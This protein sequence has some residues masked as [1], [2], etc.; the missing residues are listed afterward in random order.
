M[1]NKIIILL[2]FS[3]IALLFVV[4]I[5]SERYTKREAKGIAP[6]SSKPT[7]QV[8]ISKTEAISLAK[9]AGVKAGYKV[10]EYNFRISEG[11]LQGRPEWYFYFE[12]KRPVDYLGGDQHFGVSVDKETGQTRVYGGR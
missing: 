9:E 6:P 1:R 11:T 10:E 5:L 3:V 7:I 4:S 8:K 2:I 12:L